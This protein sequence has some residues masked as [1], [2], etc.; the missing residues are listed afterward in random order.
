MLLNSKLMKEMAKASGTPP[1]PPGPV[2][3]EV[4]TDPP[5]GTSSLSP[6][7]TSFRFFLSN[8]FKTKDRHIFVGICN[9]DQTTV[10]R[11]LRLI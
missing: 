1:A 8:V 5:P 7:Y 10:L 3:G 6:I 2:P 11:L 9:K 4:L